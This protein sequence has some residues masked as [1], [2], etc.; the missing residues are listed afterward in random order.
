[1]AN[2]L[3]SKIL[4]ITHWVDTGWFNKK[5]FLRTKIYFMQVCKVIISKLRA[6]V[7]SIAD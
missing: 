5:M 7:L 1:M 4:K 3:F 6:Y 2:N